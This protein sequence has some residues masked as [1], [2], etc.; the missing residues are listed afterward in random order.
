MN[1]T[2]SHKLKVFSLKINTLFNRR[3]L[4]VFE[5]MVKVFSVQK[6]ITLFNRRDGVFVIMVKVTSVQK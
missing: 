1:L 5:T 2:K 3:E 4:C 6:V